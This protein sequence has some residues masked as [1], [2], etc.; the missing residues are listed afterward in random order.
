M[1]RLNQFQEKFLVKGIN[2]NRVQ[3]V[4]GMA[5][6]E[7]WDVRRWLIRV[8]G[9]G[10]WSFEVRESVM[11]SHV[12]EE[13]ESRKSGKPYLAHTVIYRVT[14][15]LTIKDPDGFVMAHYDDAATGDGPNQ[16]SLA[17]AHDLAL[18]TAVSQALKRCA[19]NLGDQFGLSLYDKG[20]TDPVVLW[21]LA[22][23]PAAVVA[24]D[25]EDKVIGSDAEKAVSA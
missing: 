9:I 12:S 23:P 8:F 18:K 24:D 13:R 14:G 22:N 10:G 21:Q 5:H 3:Q 17:D 25:S 11:V 4:Q 16:P 2:P 15:R 7:A 19:V 1:A 20:S 6:L